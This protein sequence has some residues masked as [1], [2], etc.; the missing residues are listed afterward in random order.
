MKSKRSFVFTIMCAVLF[1][2][3]F[4]TAC[5][6]ADNRSP[7]Q[8]SNEYIKECDFSFSNIDEVSVEE[9]ECMHR[10]TYKIKKGESQEK[11]KAILQVLDAWI[12]FQNDVV[13]NDEING[14]DKGTVGGTL[15]IIKC[16]FTDGSS[17]QIHKNSFMN[18]YVLNEI[19]A[20]QLDDENVYDSFLRDIMD[21]MKK[22]EYMTYH[23]DY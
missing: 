9:E 10:S 2:S 15:Y 6:P 21:I 23:I 20:C 4:A 7:S 5:K 8:K 16:V 11:D 1:I 14:W 12:A 13:F 19:D 17:V 18:N 3:I 22:D